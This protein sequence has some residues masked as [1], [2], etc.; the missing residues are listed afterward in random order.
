MAFAI[1]THS[2]VTTVNLARRDEA[3]RDPDDNVFLSTARA[4]KADYLVT[5]DHDLLDIPDSI[6][7]ALPFS[8]VKPSELLRVLGEE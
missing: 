4:G 7:G 2:R 5:N 8:I 1:R 3:S 6:Q